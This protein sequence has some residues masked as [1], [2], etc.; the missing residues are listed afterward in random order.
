MK[1]HLPS[2]HKVLDSIL[3]TI[4]GLRGKPTFSLA[5][6]RRSGFLGFLAAL[7]FCGPQKMGDGVCTLLTPAILRGQE[8]FLISVAG[9]LWKR[10]F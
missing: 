7:G 3:C 8:D 6:Y 9:V 10:E 4:L 5:T 1:E 2:T